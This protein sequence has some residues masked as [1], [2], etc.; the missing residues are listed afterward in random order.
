[1]KREF[2]YIANWKMNKSLNDCLAFAVS[3]SEEAARL[4]SR[5]D[6]TLII[7]PSHVSIYPL[8][9]VFAATPVAL[10]AQNCSRHGKGAFT[11]EISAQDL[12]EIGITYCII[13]HSERRTYHHKTDKEVAEKLVHLIDFD[14]TPIICIGETLEEFTAGKTIKVLDRQ[15]APIFDVITSTISIPQELPFIVAYEPVW[16]I[17]T[18]KIASS[19]H[20][21][22]AFAYIQSQIQRLSRELSWKLIYGG[23]T[24]AENITKLKEIPLIDGFLIGNASLDFSELK[25]IVD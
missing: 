8:S 22:T 7:C 16:S 3:L 25:K 4:A 12:H 21:E 14:I 6:T 18:G 15:L 9:K 24:N 17:G 19:E 10:G 1:M 2:L 13:G 5:A 20:L 23:S 11:G